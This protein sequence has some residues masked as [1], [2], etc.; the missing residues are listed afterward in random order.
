MP[1]WR[2]ASGPARALLGWTLICW[3]WPLLLHW[4]HV[5]FRVQ[6]VLLVDVWLRAFRKRQLDTL[7]AAAGETAATA[8]SFWA[9]HWN[10]LDLFVT[11]VS[12]LS[13]GGLVA[14]TMAE[15]QGLAWRGRVYWELLRV[16][17]PLRLLPCV[18]GSNPLTQSRF[19]SEE[20]ASVRGRRVYAESLPRLTSLGDRYTVCV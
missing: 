5:S 11:A 7:T 20:T 18:E 9:D 10:R 13:V 4:R 17:R 8:P 12:V 1:S 16:V 6:G 3:F 14:Y 15:S 19:A 2:Y